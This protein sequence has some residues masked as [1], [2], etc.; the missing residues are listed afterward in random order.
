MSLKILELFSGTGSIGKP[1]RKR[2]HEVIAVDVDGRFGCEIQDDI[3]QFAYVKLPWVPD[4]IWASPPC[5]EY[6]RAKTTGVR[7]LVLADKLVAK[8]IEIRN[9]FLEL[10]PSML[11]FCEMVRQLCFGRGML[12]KH[13]GLE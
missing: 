11:W 1:F 13:F 5:T 9:H 2:G 6:S 3:L 7:N 8:F 12:Q 4:I 10:N